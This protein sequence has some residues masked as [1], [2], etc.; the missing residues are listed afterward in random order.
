MGEKFISHPRQLFTPGDALNLTV[1]RVSPELKKL[2][3]SLLSS[4]KIQQHRKRKRL[5]SDDLISLDELAIDEELWGEIVR[6]TD[7]GAYVEVGATVQGFLH[8]MDH[9]EFPYRDDHVH[10]TD[11]MHVNQLVRLWVLRLD[12]GKN[13]IQLTGVRP[14][15]LPVLK[16]D[17]RLK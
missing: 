6:V 1:Y 4:D 10:P 14:Q 12:E 5:S 9:P 2:Q 7:Y 15:S 11:L 17:F 8:F 13:R 3:L 16:R